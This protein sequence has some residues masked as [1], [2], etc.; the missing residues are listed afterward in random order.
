MG[1]FGHVS[2]SRGWIFFTPMVGLIPGFLKTVTIHLYVYQLSGH[3]L[4]G[5]RCLALTCPF[6]DTESEQ[7][8]FLVLYFLYLLYIVL[9]GFVCQTNVYPGFE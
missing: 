9:H 7:A 4:A 1:G 6:T 8:T 3:E 2:G 5:M